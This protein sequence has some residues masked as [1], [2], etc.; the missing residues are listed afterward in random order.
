MRKFRNLKQK[1]IF[2]VMSVSILLA[3]LITVNMSIGSVHSTNTIL[4]DNMQITAR[5]ASQNIS[6]NLHLLTERMFNLSMNDTF[7]DPAVAVSEKETYMDEMEQLIEFVWLAAYDTSGSKLYGDASAPDSIADTKYFSY[8]SQTGSIVIGEPYQENN[9]LQLCV[10]IPLKSGD[11]TTAYLVGSYKYDLLND[12]LSLLIL[13]NTGSACIVN[14]SGVIIGD[15]NY[16]NIIKQQ[17]IYDLYPSSEN[18][19]IFNK[20]LSFQTGSALLRLQHVPYYVGYAPIPGTN[21]TL[22]VNVPQREYMDSMIISL[23]VTIL[24]T[25]LL[26]LLA[27]SVITPL[28]RKISGSLETA[29][30]RLQALSDGNLTEEVIQSDS[31]DETGI[32]TLAL[33]K[34][35]ASLNSYIQNIQSCLGSLADGD[36]T[37]E[38]PDTFHGDFSSIYDSLCHITDSLNQTMIRMNQSSVDVNRNSNGVSSHA[39]Q[40]YDGS[41]NQ[42]ALLEQLVESIAA[43]TSS[44]ER[45]KDNARQIE[46]CSENAGEKTSL[47]AGYM[48]DM[49]D[50]MNQVHS[51]VQEISKISKMIEDISDQTNLLSLNASIEA[52]SAGSAGRGFAVVA[53][54]I[55]RLSRQTTDA[56]Q[57]TMAIIEHSTKTIKRGLE[58]ADQTEKAFQQ[59]QSVTEQYREISAKLSETVNEQTSAVNEIHTQLASLQGIADA[60]RDLAQETDRMA[61]DSLAQ[62]ESLK[63]YVAQVKIK[64]SV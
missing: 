11:E 17:N 19:E 3:V 47:G 26:L 30:K 56:L 13:G 53:A 12:V 59:I 33:A 15:R 42:S 58:S 23:I 29:A 38:I 32:L 50:T 57:Q 54:Q 43:I 4:L 22:L 25:I 48:R 18:A 64:E 35:V 62:S 2:Y 5:I 14:E 20:A 7:L 9:V 52:A 44:I 49:L 16:Q 46:A 55:G 40:L 28:A 10:G 41:L 37:I 8:I 45:N 27:A 51:A 63:D 34:M 6:S 36:Y 24:L 61:S 60:N 31:N 21:W 39:K 1:I